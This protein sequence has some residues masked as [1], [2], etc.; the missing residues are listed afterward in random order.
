MKGNT[1]IC[2]IVD[3]LATLTG[4]GHRLFQ[5]CN[6]KVLVG[7]TGHGHGVMEILAKLVM[8]KTGCGHTGHG[9]GNTGL[10]GHGN[11]GYNGRGKDWR[12]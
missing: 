7:N 6:S 9:H 12:R 5:A 3:G 4:G 1:Y 2:R 8:G 10:N 11:T